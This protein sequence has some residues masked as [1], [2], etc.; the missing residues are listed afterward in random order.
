[1]LSNGLYISFLS[2]KSK[3][4]APRRVIPSERLTNRG[5]KQIFCAYCGNCGY[6]IE[7]GK[8]TTS[9]GEDIPNVVSIRDSTIFITPE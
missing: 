2:K 4:I 6:T 5:R 7:R 8:C 1:M 3:V 9:S